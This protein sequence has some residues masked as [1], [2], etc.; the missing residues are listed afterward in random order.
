MTLELSPELNRAAHCIDMAERLNA[1]AQSALNENNKIRFNNL[2]T[3]ANE[4]L[5]LAEL[6]IEID[7]L[8]T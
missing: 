4:Y 8:A 7:G 3:Q 6:N 2:N 5:E 1:R